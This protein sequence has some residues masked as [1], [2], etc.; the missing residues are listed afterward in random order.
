[1]AASEFGDIVAICDIDDDHLNKM[2]ANFPKARKY[3]DFR[4]ML[5]EVGEDVDGVTVST[6]DHTHAVAAIMAMKMEGGLLPEA[7]DPLRA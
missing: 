3:N 6:P 7:L 5:E 2:A 1:M 4:K